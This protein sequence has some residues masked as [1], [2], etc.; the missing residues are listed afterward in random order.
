MIPYWLVSAIAV[1]A[2]WSLWLVR[3]MPRLVRISLIV[4]ILY[5]ALAYALISVLPF[6]GYMR[7]DIIRAGVILI[8]ISIIAN[9]MIT[10]I[11]WYRWGKR[12]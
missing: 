3:P 12:L 10:R 2:A 8:F 11:A 1:I 6:D 9:S 5:T 7:M 4:P